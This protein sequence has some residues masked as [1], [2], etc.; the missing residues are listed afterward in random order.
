MADTEYNRRSFGDI[1]NRYRYFGVAVALI[2]GI[3]L[4]LVIFKDVIFLGGGETTLGLNSFIAITAVGLLI[5]FA[6]VADARAKNRAL[7]Q[8]ADK[9]GDMAKRLNVTVEE[10]NTANEE[11]ARARLQTDF[12]SQEKSLFLSDLSNE[13]DAPITAILNEVLN[14]RGE[15]DLSETQGQSID[16]L[17]LN[18][19]NLSAIVGDVVEIAR[20]DAAGGE[21]VPADFD[22]GDFIGKL[23][24]ETVR[25]AS[26]RGIGLELQISAEG[27]GVVNGDAGLLRDVLEFLLANAMDANEKG[28]VRFAVSRVGEDMYVFEIRDRGAVYSDAM[29]VSIFEPFHKSEGE[30]IKGATGL[31]LAIANKRIVAMG[32]DLKITSEAGEGCIFSFEIQL[33]ASGAAKAAATAAATA[34]ATNTSA[35]NTSATNTSAN[36]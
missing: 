13:L 27:Y 18:C 25:K 21:F 31:G 33:P 36:D 6:I 35:T 12:S 24:T 29:L 11:L 20:M 30:R 34:S 14:L 7:M 10:L 9:L 22:L 1:L 32:G 15:P 4:V 5:V 3:A 28:S 23:R 17:A 19:K 16:D 2:G 8:R 26:E